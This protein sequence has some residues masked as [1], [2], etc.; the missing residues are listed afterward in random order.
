[1]DKRAACEI[2][3]EVKQILTLPRECGLESVAS[4]VLCY[5]KADGDAARVLYKIVKKYIL[6]APEQFTGAASDKLAPAV[7]HCSAFVGA[8]WQV[9]SADGADGA[10]GGICEAI[11][12]LVF[13][14]SNRFTRHVVRALMYLKRYPAFKLCVSAKTIERT[15]ITLRFAV[16]HN[17]ALLLKLADEDSANAA[18]S[19]LRRA[20]GCLWSMYLSAL[21]IRG[22]FVS[23]ARL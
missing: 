20:M 17:P 1:M 22:W 14:T 2:E 23:F 7:L 16:E 15:L 5:G 13:H 9:L 4:K 19:Y 18:A 11:S 6:P 3:D 8:V 10:D 21:I 12:L